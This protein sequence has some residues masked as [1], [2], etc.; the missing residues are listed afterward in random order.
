M[1]Y[2]EQIFSTSYFW[3]AF[4]K[5]NNL[6]YEDLNFW[7]HRFL[8]SIAKWLS[9]W[10]YTQSVS[11]WQLFHNRA[12]RLGACPVRYLYFVSSGCRLS[13]C[14]LYIAYLFCSDI[15]VWRGHINIL[16][17]QVLVA[18]YPWSQRDKFDRSWSCIDIVSW[19]TIQGVQFKSMSSIL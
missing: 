16:W 13:L 5:I 8:D 18:L 14:Y 10:Y 2:T 4:L 9:N 1:H 15:F 19:C 17:D 6:Y 12:L 11:H 3:I 7:Q